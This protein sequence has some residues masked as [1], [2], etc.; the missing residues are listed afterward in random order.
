MATEQPSY[1]RN[2]L[3]SILAEDDVADKPISQ[4]E[5]QSMVN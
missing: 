1:Y 3:E 5:L 4:Q 2:L